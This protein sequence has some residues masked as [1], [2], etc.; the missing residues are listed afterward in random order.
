MKVVKNHVSIKLN[1]IKELN[2]RKSVINNK[3]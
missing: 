3:L 1:V 2:I